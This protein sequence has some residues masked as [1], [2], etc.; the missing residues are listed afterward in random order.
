MIVLAE[1][2]AE[3]IK[4]W[5]RDLHYS[6]K[7]I[8]AAFCI[9]FTHMAI[10]HGNLHQLHCSPAFG[11]HLCAEAIWTLKD[12]VWADGE[13]ISMIPC[14]DPFGFHMEDI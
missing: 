10:K 4:H 6:F 9:T 11:A 13:H 12:Y 14:L 2:A 1:Q 7:M 8:A 3:M 5:R